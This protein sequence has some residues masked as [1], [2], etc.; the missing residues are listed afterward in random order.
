MCAWFF[1][2]PPCRVTAG[3]C[4]EPVEHSIICCAQVGFFF[5]PNIFLNKIQ[6][7]IK[8][9][10]TYGLRWLLTPSAHTLQVHMESPLAAAA[11]HGVIMVTNVNHYPAVDIII[12][13]HMASPQRSFTSCCLRNVCA[14]KA[15]YK[16]YTMSQMC[17]CVY[18]N[19]RGYQSVLL[20]LLAVNEFEWFRRFLSYLLYC[21]SDGVCLRRECISLS[22]LDSG[23]RNSIS[24]I[25]L[26]QS[27]PKNH[28]HKHPQTQ[29]K[30]Q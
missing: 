15:N 26:E 28:T 22:D 7:L 10:I 3:A 14:Y 27:Q 4:V 1:F 18:L 19:N 2:F 17:V 29:Q 30:D 12:T 11:L 25:R 8:V 13:T 20:C 21:F 6:A 23:R 16:K 24:S 9:A 5:L